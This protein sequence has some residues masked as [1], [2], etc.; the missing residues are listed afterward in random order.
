[1]ILPES[2]YLERDEGISKS[3]FKSPLY[4]M[5]NRIVEPLHQNKSAIEMMRDLAQRMGFGTHYAWKNI[6]ELRAYQAKGNVELLQTLLMRGVASF[7]VPPLLALH[8]PSV[9]R[10]CE[11]YPKSRSWVDAQGLFSHFL[12][13]LKTP[14]GKIEIYCEEVARF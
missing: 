14:S 8:A 11:R 7:D 6:S 13:H 5:R 9:E 1:V 10:F 4:T 3:A 2:T 12:E